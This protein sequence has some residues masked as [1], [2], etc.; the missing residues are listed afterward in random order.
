ALLERL[1]PRTAPPPVA[2]PSPAA[3]A[4]PAAAPGVPAGPRAQLPRPAL[5]DTYNGD[6]TSGEHFLQ[7]CLTY[8]HLSRDAFDSDAL[9]IAWVLS[10]MKARQASTYALHVLWHLG[11]VGSFTNWAA[12]EK[13]F[14]AEFFPIDPAKSA[15]LA[16]CN[17][18]QYGQGKRMLD[19]YI[20]SFQALVEQAAYPDGLQLCLT[21]WDG[22]HSVRFC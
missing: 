4:V 21:F 10:Y 13:D 8:I 5:P 16:L 19:K 7:S 20:D 3:P 1:P 18:E 11:G 12:F 2:E 14:W 22:L 17:R 15:A 9:K 6:H